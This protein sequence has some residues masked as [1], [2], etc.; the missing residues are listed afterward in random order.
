MSPSVAVNLYLAISTPVVE[1][2]T[3]LESGVS[4]SIAAAKIALDLTIEESPIT[5]VV[6]IVQVDSLSFES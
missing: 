3:I 1:A 4:P 6:A 5:S 2:N